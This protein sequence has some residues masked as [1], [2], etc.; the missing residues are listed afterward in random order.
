MTPTRRC[1]AAPAA[2]FTLIEV[3]I[4]IVVFAIGLLAMS[5]VVPLGTG[6]VTAAG[7]QT[8]AGALV[9]ESAEELLT[10]P[11]D[12]DDLTAGTHDDD[13]NPH[14]GQYFVR[15]TVEEDQPVADC[16]RVTVRAARGSA[17]GPA[18]AQVVIVAPRSGGI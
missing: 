13:A 11:Y 14:D 15:W 12:H 8:R 10:L 18:E 6:R 4:A 7:Q 5:M 9:A 1:P 2:G 3:L 16:K 17:A